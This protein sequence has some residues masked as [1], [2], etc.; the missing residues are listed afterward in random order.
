MLTEVVKDDLFFA[1]SL[2]LNSYKRP[3]LIMKLK[4]QTFLL[5]ATWAVLTAANFSPDEVSVNVVGEVERPGL[6]QVSPNTTLNQ[7]VLAAGGFNRRSSETVELVRL[8]PNGTVTQRQVEVNLQE[9]LDAE[10]NPLILNNDVV[11]VGRNGRAR[12]S[13]TLESVLGP[14]FQFLGPLRL[15]F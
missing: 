1:F 11:V 4:L 13:D 3:L 5:A 10:R 8:N 6:L 12:F 15:L 7:A 2:T 9:G 14:V